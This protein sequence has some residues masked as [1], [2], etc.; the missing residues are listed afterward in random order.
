[1]ARRQSRVVPALVPELLPRATRELEV[2]A[3]RRA[4]RRERGARRALVARAW[5]EPDAQAD[6]R[7]G[8]QHG[9]PALGRARRAAAG[10]RP[11]ALP[12]RTTHHALVARTAA[13][14]RRLNPRAHAPPF[15]RIAH[16]AMRLQPG[17]RFFA[18]A[19]ELRPFRARRLLVQRERQGARRID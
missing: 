8:E 10:R 13:V 5:A 16:L 2:A 6:R 4:V 14:A 12:D 19:P 7:Q 11:P 15:G 18:G 9:Q 17:D 3:P 1:H